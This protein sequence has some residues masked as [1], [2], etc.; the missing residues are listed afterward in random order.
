MRPEEIKCPWCEEHTLRAEY[1]G[2]KVYLRCAQ[3]GEFNCPDTTG[4][5]DTLDEAI[6]Y[7][8]ELC[9]PKGLWPSNAK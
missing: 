9:E 4:I 1:S 7:A 2:R 8:K 6:G 5:C 3:P